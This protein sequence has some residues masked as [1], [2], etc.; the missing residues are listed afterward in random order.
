MW[1]IFLLYFYLILKPCLHS[2]SFFGRVLQ[3]TFS[4]NW[5]NLLLSLPVSTCCSSY[6]IPC[7]YLTINC[8]MITENQSNIKNSMHQYQFNMMEI[9]YILTTNYHYTIITYN[10][11][12]ASMS[13][14]KCQGNKCQ[15]ISFSSNKPTVIE[16]FYIKI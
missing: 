9:S 14:V 4:E 1:K 2:S 12:I 10:K 7:L 5:I 15:A 16:S 11:V 8:L 13:G 6:L 3:Y